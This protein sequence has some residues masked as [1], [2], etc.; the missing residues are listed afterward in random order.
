MG[1]DRFHPE[2]N[3]DYK[4]PLQGIQAHRHQGAGGNTGDGGSLRR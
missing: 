2:N 3:G 1:G 4:S